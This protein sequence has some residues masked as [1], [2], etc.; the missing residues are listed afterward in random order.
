MP[1]NGSFLLDTNIV[2]ALFRSEP[3]VL[4]KL[5]TAG[6]VFVPTTTLG[7]LYYGARC[8]SRIHRNLERVNRFVVTSRVLGC[9]GNT[10]RHYGIVKSR[11]R[12]KGR[13]IPENDIWIA[14]LARQHE[15][16]VA[17]RDRHFEAVDD[18]EL[19]IW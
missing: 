4:Q 16:T 11:L 17:T 2:I 18:V 5:A 15:L 13:P 14:A 3:G 8:S 7:E 10:S 12:Q 1:A 6:Q 9:D 19:E